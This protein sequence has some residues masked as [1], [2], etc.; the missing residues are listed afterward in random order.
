MTAMSLTQFRKQLTKKLEEVGLADE[1]LRPFVCTGSPLACDIMM[2]GYNPSRDMGLDTFDARIWNDKTGFDREHFVELYD[3]A[4]HQ[5]G[6]NRWSRNHIFQQ[7]LIDEL[8]DYA[9][10]ET[11]LYS[12]ITPK[13]SLVPP[14][15][16]H[17]EIFDWLVKVIQPKLIVTQNSE[18]SRYFE[19]V[20]NKT[21]K[22]NE[23]NAV[24]YQGQP[25]VILPISHLSKK[26]TFAEIGVLRE[27][28]LTFLDM[29]EAS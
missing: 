12:M 9:V 2:V 1:K 6:E 15:H 19:R 4:G 11:Y 22:R 24:M 7:N 28:V 13:K 5:Q 17:T 8:P 29:L 14:Q 27:S 18:V 20:T 25:C 16:R 26:W 21:L 10:L 3:F 23:F